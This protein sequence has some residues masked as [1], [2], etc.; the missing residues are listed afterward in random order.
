MLTGVARSGGMGEV[1]VLL[2]EGLLDPRL[3]TRDTAK[4]TKYL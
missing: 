3:D 1:A 2:N 4:L